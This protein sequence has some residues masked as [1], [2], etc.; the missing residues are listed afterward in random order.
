MLA[1]VNNQGE[2]VWTILPSWG[3]DY[4][5]R[6]DEKWSVGLHTDWVVESFEYEHNAIVFER[7]RPFA[8]VIVGSRK[9]GDHLTLVLGGGVELAPEENLNIVRLGLDYS[10]ELPNEWELGASVMSD[11]K[12]DAYNSWVLGLGVAKLF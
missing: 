10:W 8:A 9:F 12:L 7:T 6:L 5:Y 11:F 1:G 4:D 3:I 2:K